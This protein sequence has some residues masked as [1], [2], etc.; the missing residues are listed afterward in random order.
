MVAG[1][2]VITSPTISSKP[3]GM[4]VS[5]LDDIREPGGSGLLCSGTNTAAIGGSS[6]SAV[7]IE[8]RNR[9]MFGHHTG[10]FR[11]SQYC[12]SDPDLLNISCISKSKRRPRPDGTLLSST[13][14]AGICRNPWSFNW[15]NQTLDI[16][17]LMI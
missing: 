9:V 17:N 11:D 12:V 16:P 14:P 13:A 6:V 8:R 3:I 15:D 5:I 2:V 7:N 10:S 1:R 4:H